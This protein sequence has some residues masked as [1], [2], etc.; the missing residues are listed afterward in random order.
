[1]YVA[2]S[3]VKNN[4]VYI[5]HRVCVTQKSVR[6]SWVLMLKIKKKKIAVS[7]RPKLWTANMR[8]STWTP[9]ICFSTVYT[10]KILYW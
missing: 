1:M 4:S 8:Y 2:M 5:C 3:F 7:T 6:D 10:N 9:H